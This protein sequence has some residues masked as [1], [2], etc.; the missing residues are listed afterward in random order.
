MSCGGSFSSLIE[1]GL[2]LVVD[3]LL[4]GDSP[5]GLCVLPTVVAWHV[6][7]VAAALGP[8]RAAFGLFK[9]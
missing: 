1:N 9:I 2:S 4:R 7:L 8:P 3:L 5:S 6:A